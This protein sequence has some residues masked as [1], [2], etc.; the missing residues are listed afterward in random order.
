MFAIDACKVRSLSWLHLAG[1][2]SQ[3]AAQPVVV[4]VGFNVTV[5]YA[6]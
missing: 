6:S 1:G 3:D 4:V 5:M 2:K